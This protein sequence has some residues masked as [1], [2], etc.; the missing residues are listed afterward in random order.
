MAIETGRVLQD[1]INK[2][3]SEL[4]AMIMVSLGINE[5]IISRE[6]MD[7]IAFHRLEF[8]VSRSVETDSI[9]VTLTERK[10]NGQQA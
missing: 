6:A 1:L 7:S 8:S 5:V 9:V 10:S 3:A 4:A 2:R